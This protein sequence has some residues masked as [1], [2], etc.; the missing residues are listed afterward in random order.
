MAPSVYVET[1]VISDRLETLSLPP[2][3][4]LRESW[5]DAREK[6]DVYMSV[7]VVEKARCGGAEAAQRPLAA[8]SGLPI[9]GINEAAEKLGSAC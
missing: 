7:L 6:L 3:R 8:I 2:G 1:S 4:P 9:L 5:E